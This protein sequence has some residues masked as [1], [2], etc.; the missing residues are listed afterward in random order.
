VQIQTAV[1]SAKQAP[2]KVLP[3]PAG[4]QKARQTLLMTSKTPRVQFEGT[5]TDLIVGASVDRAKWKN[6]R[7]LVPKDYEGFLLNFWIM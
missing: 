7:R 4:T 3:F 1:A 6:C 2:A 5:N